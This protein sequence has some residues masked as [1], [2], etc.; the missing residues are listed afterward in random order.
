MDRKQD[1]P[2][3]KARDLATLEAS[4]LF[5]S[6]YYLSQCP[7]LKGRGIDL[8][9]HYLLVG[10]LQ[11]KSPNPDFDPDFYCRAHADQLRDGDDAFVHYLRHGAKAG[12]K[13]R[14]TIDRETEEIPSFRYRALNSAL[15]DWV[16]AVEKPRDSQIISIIIPVLNQ[17]ELTEACIDSL[18]QFT[19][20]GRFELIVVDNGSDLPTQQLLQALAAKHENLYLVRNEENLNFSLGCNL[21]FAA[22]RGENI[23]FLNNDTTVAEGWLDPLIEPLSRQ[24]ISAVQ[25]CLLYPDGSIQCMGVVFSDKS[26]LGYP[27]YQGMM[28]AKDWADRSQSFQAVTGACIAL[29]AADF[30]SLRGFD[31]LYING[32]EDVDL[33][34]R[35][36]QM[37]KRHCW[38]AAN[39][40]IAHVGA[41][42]TGRFSYVTN[43]RKAFIRRWKGKIT[44]DD[45]E[46]YKLDQFH[47]VDWNLDSE[48]NK[49]NDVGIY[50]PGCSSE[51]A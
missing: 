43:N 20:P 4:G 10:R 23:V 45:M 36:N 42:S 7:H 49:E 29:R 38:L 46:H 19:Q 18:Y 48:R 17:P 25:P 28:P 39:S 51:K 37:S 32:Q 13:L 31:P 8:L 11:G 26:P 21:G 16:S 40:K 15:I 6:E 12:L 9:T 14:E 47:V 44:P 33:C 50:L 35:L 2:L 30:A 34:L 5:D 41:A 1:S 3:V 24:E 22:S 27:I